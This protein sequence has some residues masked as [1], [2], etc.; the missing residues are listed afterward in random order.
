MPEVIIQE[1]E[2]KAKTGYDYE[3]LI[4]LTGI[5]GIYTQSEIANLRS[6]GQYSRK[7]FYDDIGVLATLCVEIDSVDIRRLKIKILDQDEIYIDYFLLNPGAKGQSLGYKR[8]HS[9]IIEARNLKFKKLSL[10]AYGNIHLYNSKFRWEGYIVWGKYGFT[11]Y[12]PNQIAIFNQRMSDE[13][14]VMR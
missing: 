11:M 7:V 5:L 1:H 2:C 9:Q 8:L 13:R 3:D 10:E 4:H 14:S 12:E 6:S